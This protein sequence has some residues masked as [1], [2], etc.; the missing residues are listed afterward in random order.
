M[1]PMLAATIK[2]ISTLQFPLYASPKLDG[3]RGVVVDGVLKSRSL[4][5][6]PNEFVTE[7]FS[8]KKYNGYDGELIL[9]SPTAKDVY[10]VT[11]AAC[12]RHIGRP[13]V[14][15]YVFDNYLSEYGF[16]DR[17]NDIEFGGPVVQHEHTLIQNA[18]EL[19]AFENDCLDFGYEGV[20]LRGPQGAYKFG[21][22]T[23]REQGMM[24][25]KRFMD[26][27]AIILDIEEEMENTNAKKTNELGRTARSHAQAGM[28][29]KGRAGT[30]C[31]RDLSSE[32][33]FR[34]GTGLSDSDKY[35]FWVNRKKLI[36]KIIKYKSFKIGVKDK[37]RHP[38]YIGPREKFDL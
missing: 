16:G 13:A 36:G 28:V 1:R 21:R 11:N 30:L 35:Y 38:V 20:I 33:E 4:K 14:K 32:V 31:V 22:S 17:F 3:I 12:A 24:K 27:E 15:F 7:M 19:L 9:G 25:L 6:I 26:S 23:L 34:V 37:P 10:R 2:D 29:P 5:P 18:V 8:K